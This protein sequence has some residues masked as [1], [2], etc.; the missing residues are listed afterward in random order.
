[1]SAPHT[2]ADRRYVTSVRE[3]LIGFPI[4]SIV[5]VAETRALDLVHVGAD[6]AGRLGASGA[7]AYAAEIENSQPVE[8]SIGCRAIF[9]FSSRVSHSV[10]PNK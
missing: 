7:R 10:E 5:P 3:N 1:M 4:A 8:E 2:G 6:L 9:S